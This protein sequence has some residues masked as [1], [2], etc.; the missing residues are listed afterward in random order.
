MYFNWHHQWLHTTTAATRWEWCLG[1]YIPIELAHRHKNIHIK[2]TR[3]HSIRSYLPQKPIES[4]YTSSNQ[5]QF[6][7]TRKLHDYTPQL[8]QFL[9]RQSSYNENTQTIIKAGHRSRFQ[10]RQQTFHCV[11]Y[12]SC[13]FTNNKCRNASW[14]KTWMFREIDKQIRNPSSYCT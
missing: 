5:Q 1:E 11:T 3:N 13:R 14:Q 9:T 7:R 12:N 4:S 8:Q 6:W 2:A 10:I